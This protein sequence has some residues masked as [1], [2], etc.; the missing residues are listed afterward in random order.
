MNERY[1]YIYVLKEKQSTH[2]LWLIIE[3]TITQVDWLSFYVVKID[4]NISLFQY[5]FS[6]QMHIAE[7]NVFYLISNK[8]TFTSQR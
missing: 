2:D 6:K 7:K 8:N 1:V 3:W 5:S 4:E